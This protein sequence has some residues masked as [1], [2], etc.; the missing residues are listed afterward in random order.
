LQHLLTLN[1]LGYASVGESRVSG[2][3]FYLDSE[4]GGSTLYF[5]QFDMKR[6]GQI[7]LSGRDSL[8]LLSDGEL[9]AEFNPDKVTLSWENKN[10]HQ[11]ATFDEIQLAMF[12]DIDL[13][14]LLVLSRLNQQP[15]LL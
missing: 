12:I 9:K 6:L 13:V 11:E 3:Y 1:K 15:R 5:S 2:R 8:A 7:I 14:R 10:G 4:S